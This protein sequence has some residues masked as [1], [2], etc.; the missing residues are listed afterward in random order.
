M[1]THALGLAS[2]AACQHHRFGTPPIDTASTQK[3]IEGGRQLTAPPQARD[4][5]LSNFIYLGGQ[6]FCT[7]HPISHCP[8]GVP[9]Y[10][11]RGPLRWWRRLSLSLR[12]Y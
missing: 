11:T 1:Q 4:C 12:G 8:Y 2:I 5:R 10:P 3:T 7:A 6:S 9:S